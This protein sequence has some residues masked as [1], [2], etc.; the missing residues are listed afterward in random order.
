MQAHSAQAFVFFGIVSAALAVLPAGAADPLPLDSQAVTFF[1]QKIRPI[2]SDHCLKCHSTEA[3]QTKK[4]KAGL[5]LDTR[6]GTR[7]G[8]ESGPVI[9]PHKAAD[10]LLIQALRYDGDVRMPPNGKLPEAV[11][12]DFEKWVNMGAPDPRQ[13]PMGG[14]KQVGMTIEAGRHFWA[15]KPPELAAVPAVKAADWPRE[16]IDHFVLANLEAKGL[17]PAPD[18]DR[19]TLAR[20]LYFDLIGLPP[21]PEDVD[22]FAGDRDPRA[23][24]RLV[25]KLLASPQFG[26]RWGRHWLDVARYAE[27]VTLRGFIFKEAWRYRDYVIDVF[28]RDVPFDQFVREQIAGDLLPAAAPVDRRRQLT[29]TTFLILG[30]TNLEEQDKKQLRMDV[31]DEQLDVIGKGLLAQTITCARCHDHKFDP[32]PTRDYYALAGILRNVKAMEHA[33]VSRWVEMPLP[34]DPG[35]EAVLRQHEEAVAALQARIKA[36]KGATTKGGVLAVR[37]LPGIVVDDSDAKKIGAWQVSRYSG[38]YIGTGFVHDQNM[39][40]G[41]KTLTFQPEVIP[42]GKYEVRLAY[43]PGTNRAEAVPVTVFSADG[44]KTITVNMKQDPAIDGRFISLGEYR[45]EKNGLGYVL[46]SNEGTIGHV[47]ADA[48]MFLPLDG[49]D[50]SAKPA[51]PAKPMGQR[52]TARALEAELRR[53]QNM[54]PKRQMVMTVLEE[55]QIEEAQIH[56]RGSVHNLGEIAPRGFLQV[57]TWGAPP[58]IPKGQSGRRE[59]AEW[60]AA[61]E[62][63]LTARVFVNRAWHWL[64]GDGIVRTTDN[65]GTTGER[66][67]HP[68]LLDHLAVSF[69]ADGWSMKKLIRRIVLSRTYQQSATGDGS[70]DPENRLFGRANRRRLE[71]E[72]LRDTMLSISGQLSQQPGGPMFPA[73][74]SADYGY[75]GTARCRSVYLPMFRNALPE[76][77]ELFDAADPSM[78]TGRRNSGTVAPQALFFMNHP[79]PAEQAR[80]AAARL[81]GEKLPDDDARITR[82]YRWTLGREPTAGERRVAVRFLQA[83]DPIEV[84]AMLFHALFASADFRYVN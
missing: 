52:D 13:G 76:I 37:D 77:L 56:V 12:A 36:A 9:V 60:I 21:T 19:A 81:L 35:E 53:L 45:F 7:R 72:C 17:R 1:E 67:S 51:R 82:A 2:L 31:V 50:V 59:L 41:E 26:E 74:L 8:G 6:D 42:P 48:V 4:L 39:G 43:V 20:R 80:H 64:F 18:A 25:D 33:N 73:S 28:N 62:N 46:I 24:E 3:E 22:A 58:S 69:V 47:I 75:Q 30:N 5:Y 44:E 14:R 34:A 29:A 57:A 79:F 23:Y 84:W 27:S 66:P 49:S 71:A 61:P 65:F 68:E 32:I 38:T 70:A 54:G 83:Q 15:Y 78:V 63:P 10:S 40:K 55:K 11:I 16:E